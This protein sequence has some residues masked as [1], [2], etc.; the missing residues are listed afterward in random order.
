MIQSS[1]E[2]CSIGND[3]DADD[4]L[5]NFKVN[6]EDDIDEQVRPIYRLI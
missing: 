6:A 3:D 2:G 5:S 1:E 4:G